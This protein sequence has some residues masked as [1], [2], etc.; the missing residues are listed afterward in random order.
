MVGVGASSVSQAPEVTVPSACQKQQRRA[1]GLAPF[2]HRQRLPVDDHLVQPPGGRRD[3][4]RVS[5][6]RDTEGPKGCPPPD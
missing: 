4:H 3:A 5:M 2:A 6:P 1:V